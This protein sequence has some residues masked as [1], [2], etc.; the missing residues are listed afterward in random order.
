MSNALN[1]KKHKNPTTDKK[2]KILNMGGSAL[3]LKIL[4]LFEG[5]Q[6]D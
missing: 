3:I 4:W 6:N 1:K 5:V 2:P